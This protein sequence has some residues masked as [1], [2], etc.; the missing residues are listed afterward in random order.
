MGLQP[1]GPRGTVGARAR[2]HHHVSVAAWSRRERERS[3]SAVAENA[4][5]S[6]QKQPSG[7]ERVTAHWRSET[8]GQPAGRRGNDSR[9]LVDERDRRARHRAMVSTTIQSPNEARTTRNY[10]GPKVVPGVSVVRRERRYDGAQRETD[11]V[12]RRTASLLG[13]RNVPA[14][15][16]LLVGELLR[17][18]LEGRAPGRQ[19]GGEGS[20]PF[21]R[22]LSRPVK[23]LGG[24]TIVDRSG[25]VRFP[26]GA[27]RRMKR[28]VHGR[29]FESDR[30]SR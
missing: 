26:Y 22:S 14:V 2:L 20:I 29:R 25:R 23:L 4:R 21:I 28:G 10:N 13:E 27:P 15:F 24:W 12:A 11:C 7:K 9:H 8:E 1:R 6:A 30:A 3:F 5:R 17:M 18:Q 16:A 19:P